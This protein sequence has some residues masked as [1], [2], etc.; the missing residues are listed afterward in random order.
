MY[1]EEVNADSCPT[2]ANYATMLND[3]RNMLTNTI[4]HSFSLLGNRLDKLEGKVTDCDQL[5]A[6]QQPQ[7]GMPLNFYDNQTSL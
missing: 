3:T 4:Q 6:V 7:F 2:H 1:D 5:G